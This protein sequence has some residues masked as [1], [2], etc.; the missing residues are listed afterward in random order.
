MPN[1]AAAGKRL[2]MGIAHVPISPEACPA[3]PESCPDDSGAMPKG[4]SGPK[5]LTIKAACESDSG[6]FSN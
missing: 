6:L 5:K 3:T 1:G 2:A 4:D